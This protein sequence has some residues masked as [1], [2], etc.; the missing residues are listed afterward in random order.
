MAAT[1]LITLRRDTSTSRRA[2]P[3]AAIARVPLASARRGAHVGYGSPAAATARLAWA[4]ENTPRV[5]RNLPVKMRL[6]TI[7]CAAFDAL[8]ARSRVIQYQGNANAIGFQHQPV[9]AG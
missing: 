9:A 6:K 5:R 1:D 4:D 2:A 8:D 7:S 3:V